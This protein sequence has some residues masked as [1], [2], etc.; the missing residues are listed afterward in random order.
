MG[1]LPTAHQ[2]DD[3]LLPPQ[4]FDDSDGVSKAAPAGKEK[5]EWGNEISDLQA[6]SQLI[7]LDTKLKLHET[8]YAEYVARRAT[9]LG[10]KIAGQVST[11]LPATLAATVK[12]QQRKVIDALFKSLGALK[13]CESCGGVS[14]GYRKD[15]YTKI[16]QREVSKRVRRSGNSRKRKLK[17]TFQNPTTSYLSPPRTCVFT[18]RA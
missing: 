1:D 9:A 13:K 2:L 15:G 14:P 3:L 7:D 17:V 10:S 8:R 5:S 6:A 12:T 18:D 16:F 4:V 11:G